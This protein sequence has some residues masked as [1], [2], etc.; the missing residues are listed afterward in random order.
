MLINNTGSDTKIM[1]ISLH[2]QN[3][4][5]MQHKDNFTCAEFLQWIKPTVINNLHVSAN[6][7]YLYLPYTQLAYIPNPS[8]S[9]AHHICSN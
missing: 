3:N 1:L 6:Q 2:W 7:C 5:L 4:N 8:S 9:L